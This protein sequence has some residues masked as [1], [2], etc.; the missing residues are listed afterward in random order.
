MIFFS[1]KLIHSINEKNKT[2]ITKELNDMHIQILIT[3]YHYFT[4]K[5]LELLFINTKKS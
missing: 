4:L 5:L 2:H 1:I 3:K